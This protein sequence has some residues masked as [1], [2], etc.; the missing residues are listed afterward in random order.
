MKVVIIGLGI[1]GK[2]RLAVAGSQVAATVDPFV[3]TADFKN[4]EQVPLDRYQAAVVASTARPAK[5]RHFELSAD[6]WQTRAGRE[7]AAGR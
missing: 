3:P 4:I 1:Q 2:K 5:D 6:A 7:T